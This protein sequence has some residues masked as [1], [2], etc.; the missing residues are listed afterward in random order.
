MKYSGYKYMCDL[1]FGIEMHTRITRS[2]VV[3]RS[4][5]G[6]KDHTAGGNEKPYLAIIPKRGSC[7]SRLISQKKEEVH[8]PY[9]NTIPTLN[10]I[11]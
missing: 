8:D 6:P 10:T 1:V 3:T 9:F 11:Y 2:R 4:R 5:E 7:K